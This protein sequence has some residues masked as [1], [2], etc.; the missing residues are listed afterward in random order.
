MPR[1]VREVRRHGDRPAVTTCYYCEDSPI[2]VIITAS[3]ADGTVLDSVT[4]C[5]SCAHLSKTALDTIGLDLGTVGRAWRNFAR[6][7]KN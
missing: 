5:A 6:T 4:M 7:R 3:R 2:A 1:E